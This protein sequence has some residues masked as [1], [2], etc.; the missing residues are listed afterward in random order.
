MPSTSTVCRLGDVPDGDSR[1][2]DPWLAGRDSVFVVRRQTQAYAYAN[3]C[4][5]V[6]G[7]PLAWRKDKYLNAA[8]TRVVC[9][10]HGAEFDIET[11]ACLLGPCLGEN[12]QSVLDH[13]SDDGQVILRHDSHNIP[14]FSNHNSLETNP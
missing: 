9:S 13:L 6:D 4:P 12:L 5:H 3:A 14:G 1:G 10:G 2:F 8:K 7:S 11:G